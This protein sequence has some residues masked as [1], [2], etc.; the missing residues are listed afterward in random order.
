M[1]IRL[2]KEKGPRLRAPGDRESEGRTPGESESEGRTPGESEKGRG[3]TPEER[4]GAKAA[5]L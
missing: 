2:A 1:A 3:Y 4:A 5:R